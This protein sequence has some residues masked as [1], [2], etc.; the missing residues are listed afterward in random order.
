VKN[1]Q[2]IGT[3]YLGNLVQGQSVNLRHL[4]E[5]DHNQNDAATH[6]PFPFEKLYRQSFRSDGCIVGIPDK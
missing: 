6:S 3:S 4:P 5:Q 1:Q 2:P